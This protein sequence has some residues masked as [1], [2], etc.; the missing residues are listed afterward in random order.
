MEELK[1]TAKSLTELKLIVVDPISAF[2]GKTDINSSSEVR[3]L[4]YELQTIAGERECAVILVTHNN[5]NSS[6][7]AVSRATGSHAFVAGPRMT[8]VFGLHPPRDGEQPV[9]GECAMVPLKNNLTKNPPALV[10]IIKPDTV[11]GENDEAIETSKIEWRGTSEVTSQE[12]MDYEPEKRAKKDGRPDNR[13]RQCVEEMSRIIG[14]KTVL[15]NDAVK[16][17][18]RELADFTEQMIKKTREYLG[19]KAVSLG[20]ESEWR[21]VKLSIDEQFDNF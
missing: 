17:L 13:F 2:M 1:R 10:Y 18:K 8:Y 9:A 4:L 14:D 7:K 5:K 19:F 15:N 11:F 12:I 16:A 21:K 20:Y 6:Q 3:G